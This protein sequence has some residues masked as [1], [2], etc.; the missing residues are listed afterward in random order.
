MRIISFLSMGGQTR[1]NY[2]TIFLPY[3]KLLERGDLWFSQKYKKAL[4]EC[5][6]IF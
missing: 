4:T 6:A 3:Q 2:N 1:M 5:V